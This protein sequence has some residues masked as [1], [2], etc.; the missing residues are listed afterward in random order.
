VASLNTSGRNV[1]PYCSGVYHDS[2]FVIL[3]L[4]KQNHVAGVLRF[5]CSTDLRL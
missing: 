5:Y 3:E 1:V 2:D 4:Y